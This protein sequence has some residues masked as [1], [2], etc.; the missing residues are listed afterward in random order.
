MYKNDYTIWVK[1]RN[2]WEVVAN[3]FLVYVKYKTQD[4]NQNCTWILEIR[5]KNKEAIY[6]EMSHE[7]FV[8]Q[9]G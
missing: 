4:E 1:T 9:R 2:N 7:D 8:R 3:N 5:I 6:I